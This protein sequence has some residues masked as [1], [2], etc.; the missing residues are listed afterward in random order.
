M[1]RI[2]NYI[3]KGKC[4]FFALFAVLCVSGLLV[5]VHQISR[6]YFKY[7]TT[8]KT[9][10]E[11]QEVESYQTIFFCPGYID[12]LERSQFKS[13]GIQTDVRQNM[14]VVS[15]ALSILTVK[16]ILELTPNVSGIIKGCLVRERSLSL[17][18]ILTSNECK[19]FFN[20]WKSVNGERVCYTFMPR[21]RTSYSVGNVASS[22]TH[23]RIAY[24]LTLSDSLAKTRFAYFISYNSYPGKPS[25]PLLSRMFGVNVDNA[26]SYRWSTFYV[27]YFLL[28]IFKLPP[29]YDTQC[30]NRK[31][32]VCYELCLINRFKQINR[33]PWSGFHR[34]HIDMKMFT[35]DDTRNQTMVKFAQNVFRHCLRCKLNPQ[36]YTSF[37]VT[38]IHVNKSS[39]LKLQISSMIPFWPNTKIISVPLVTLVD[40]LVQVGSCLGVWFGFS[41][42]S[43]D[44]V[45]IMSK[46]KA[47]VESSKGT[48]RKF[49]RRQF[50]I[51][52]GSL[53]TPRKNCSCGIC[54]TE[55]HNKYLHNST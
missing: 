38:K 14:E 17:P 51:Q 55:Y 10:F 3:Q 19:E 32:Q 45:K 11:V 4:T 9:K 24:L 33:I 46:R 54:N 41:I 6:N 40:Y 25:D 5:Q 13:Y 28:K 31:R 42:L 30:K 36:C 39:G 50:V 16:Q 53:P 29:P 35:Y 18:M 47:K 2:S 23:P 48:R 43:L 7:Q 15:K 34:D 49:N 12:L 1:S 44:P 27:S 21:N 26:N 8:T 22:F 20:I 37:S 52:A